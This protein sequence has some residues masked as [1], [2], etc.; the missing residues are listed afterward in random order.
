MDEEL[1]LEQL[2]GVRAGMTNAARDYFYST[3]DTIF[4][5]GK[6]QE[7]MMSLEELSHFLG[8]ADPHA[9]LETARNN[10]DMYSP[11]DVAWLEEQVNNLESKGMR[12]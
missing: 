6:A 3:H 7:Q 12:R 4:S 11:E 1:N 5:K 10:P 9:V 2:E 8:G